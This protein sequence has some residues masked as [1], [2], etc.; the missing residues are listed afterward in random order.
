MPRRYAPK[1][2]AKSQRMYWLPGE[3]LQLQPVHSTTGTSVV[4]TAA[5]EESYRRGVLDA[6][7]MLKASDDGRLIALVARRDQ[8]NEERWVRLCESGKGGV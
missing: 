1:Y 8:E 7:A 6:L 5:M 2:R 4:L 3:W